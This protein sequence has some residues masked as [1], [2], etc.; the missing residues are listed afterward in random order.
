MDRPAP[1]RAPAAPPGCVFCSIV[2]RRAPAHIVGESGS[3]LAFLTIGPL[4]EGHALVVPKRHVVELTDASSTEAS[5]LLALGTRI[6]E[7]QRRRLGSQGETLFL[8]SGRAGEQGVLHLHL[9]VVPR[10]D[11]DGLDLNRWWNERVAT[12]SPLALE[13]VARRLRT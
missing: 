4:R 7:L 8:M 2:A 9:H 1:A 11:G 5:E 6:A 13:A 12:A 10:S 3:A